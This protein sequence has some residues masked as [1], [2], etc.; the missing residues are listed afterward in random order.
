[1]KGDEVSLKL[2]SDQILR[3]AKRLEDKLNTMFNNVTALCYASHPESV[4]MATS[5][6]SQLGIDLPESAES[7]FKTY[8]ERTKILLKGFT[9]QD[10]IEYK[11]M[12]DPSKIM[13]M[14]FLERLE[15]SLQYTRPVAASI[16][17][18]HM[19]R[20]S[21]DHGMSP[22]LPLGF[23][24]FGQHD[25]TCGDIKQGCRYVNLAWKLMSRIGSKEFVGEVI[26]MGSQVLHFAKPIQLT[27][28]YHT[29]GFTIATAAGDMPGAN[30]QQYVLLL[31]GVLIWYKAHCLQGAHFLYLQ[32]HGTAW[33]LQLS[34]SLDPNVEKH[35]T[36]DG[37]KCW[38]RRNVDVK[39]YDSSGGQNLAKCKSY[40][41]NC[42]QFPKDVSTFYVSR[43]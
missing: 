31:A 24:Y 35:S 27:R 32:T 39:C 22:V 13:A 11:I 28:D 43:I 36:V 7:D 37:L 9:D 2:V 29:E 4:K 5:V 10:L 41:I 8:I 14:K 19:I 40:G 38:P 25:A 26:A 16:V 15:L 1:M 3:F 21:I 34:C 6:L 42:F 17:T 23:S 20:L 12:T 33:P 30:V 18:M